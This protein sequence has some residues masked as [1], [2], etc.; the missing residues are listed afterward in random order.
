ME[1]RVTGLPDIRGDRVPDRRA[2]SLDTDQRDPLNSI[3][4]ISKK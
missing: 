1:I 3:V 2:V 4:S